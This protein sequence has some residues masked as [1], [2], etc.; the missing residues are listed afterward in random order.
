MQ[1]LTT[2]RAV[3]RVMRLYRAN[4]APRAGLQVL[5]HL[6]KKIAGLSPIPTVFLSVT[7][8]C[9]ARCPHCYA[10]AEG[11]DAAAELTTA[12]WRLVLERV[13]AAG[14]LQTFFTG[15]E[16]LL[17]EDLPDLVAHAHRQGLL[18]RVFTNGY[19]LTPKVIARLKRAGLTQCCVSIDDADPDAHDRLRGLPGSFARAVEA[20][21]RLREEG[22]DRRILVYAS[23]DKIPA[24]LE[25][26]IALGASLGV[27]SVHINIPFA[28]G[29]WDA[30]D[31]VVLSAAEM[32]SLRA[33][34]RRHPRVTIEFPQPDTSCCGLA[35]K[36]ACVNT[37]G[38]VL[39]CA[40]VPFPIGFLAEESFD[41][42]WGRHPRTSGPQWRGSC[43][44]NCAEGRSLLEEQ[45]RMLRAGRRIIRPR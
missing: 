35:G 36:I 6:R 16:P 11:R 43:P 27:A 39:L 21:A 3:R 10:V 24:G 9:Q 23:H 37:R 18:T 19:L 30:N 2:L 29:R 40:A 45:A 7:Y 12:E 33:L 15:G 20:L 22:I 44:L 26:L 14:A 1:L 38:E 13:R 25:R 5:R 42:I 28:V 17:R 4:L 32:E 31:A 8:R 34:V 41:E